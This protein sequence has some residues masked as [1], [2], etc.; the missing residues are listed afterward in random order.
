VKI[1]NCTLQSPDV[2]ASPRI[3]Y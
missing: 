1:S 3:I 2:A